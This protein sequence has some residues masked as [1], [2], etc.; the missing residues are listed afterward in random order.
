MQNNRFSIRCKLF[1]V[2]LVT[3]FLMNVAYNGK[4]VEKPNIVWLI[5]EDLSPDL[6]CYGHPLVQTPNIDKLADQGIRFENA[7]ATCPVCSPSRSFLQV[8]TRIQLRQII[9]T[10]WKR[11]NSRFQKALKLCPTFFTKLV[12]LWT[13]TG[14]PISTLNMKVMR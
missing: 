2:I 4:S 9:T 12:I 8:F 14:K 1:P 7:F 5:A 11:T 3:Y 13:T 10:P 6:G